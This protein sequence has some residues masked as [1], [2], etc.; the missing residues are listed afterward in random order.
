MK[1]AILLLSVCAF[2]FLV[3]GQNISNAGFENWNITIDSV[4]FNYNTSNAEIIA[5]GGSPNVIRTADAKSGRS[6]L[7]IKNS[8]HNSQDYFGGLFLGSPGSGGL[9]GGYPFSQ[10]PDSFGFYYKSKLDADTGFIYLFF[11]KD[12]DVIGVAGVDLMGNHSVY[13]RLCTEIVFFDSQTPDTV[14]MVVFSGDMNAINSAGSYVQLDSLFLI[15]ATQK[16]P[17]PSFELWNTF[18]NEVVSDWVSSNMF[19]VKGS[20]PS[21][22][23]STEKHGGNFSIKITTALGDGGFPTGFITNGNMNDFPYGGTRIYGNPQKLGFWYKSAPLVKDTAIVLISTTRH[24]IAGD[25][26]QEIFYKV[27]KLNAAANWT[28][29]EISFTYNN[30]SK[31]VDSI[32]MAFASSNLD[33]NPGAAKVGS[34]L[35]VDDI[36]I[37]YYPNAISKLSLYGIKAWPVPASSLLQLSLDQYQSESAKVQ[38]F[39]NGGIL[40]KVVNVNVNDGKAA[41]DISNLPN[42]HYLTVISSQEKDWRIPFI[43]LH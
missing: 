12:G 16:L 1:K 4:P 13:T 24:D 18:Q 14:A 17:N 35:L 11:K 19:L 10:K 7:K 2:T 29:K 36:S 23:K 5:A 43:V 41:V 3:K 20:L 37:A 26:M 39:G 6:A 40:I 32:F 8:I 34:N 28:Y 27:I 22:V 42:G 30:S 33:E 21:V 31:R 25:T 15:G 38:I 9:T